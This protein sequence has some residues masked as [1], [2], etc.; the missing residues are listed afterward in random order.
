MSA[1][2]ARR[3][4]TRAR[5]RSP[6]I[7]GVREQLLEAAAEET[8][9]LAWCGERLRELG[10]RPSLLNPLWYG[11]AYA[12]GAVAGLVSDRLSLGFV[13]E[14][15]RQVEAHL[16]GHLSKLPAVRPAQSRDRQP[17]EGRRGAPR[18]TG[19]SRRRRGPAG[20]GAGRDALGGQCDARGG[21]SGSRDSGLRDSG[22]GQFA[23]G[24]MRQVRRMHSVRSDDEIREFQRHVSSGG[25]RDPGFAGMTRE[26]RIGSAL[27]RIPN[28]E[29]RIPAFRSDCGRGT[30]PRS[31]GGAGRR[32]AG[33][34]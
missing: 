6:A 22:F 10:D 17:D 7:P 30:A 12:I 31:R 21:L 18:R 28:P 26:E 24:V 13:V 3:R 9:H 4:S 32:C 14:T 15:E 5:P 16:Q 23:F 33:A 1:R 25:S 34:P 27:C 20:T 11:G 2:S 8:D 19:P 29:S